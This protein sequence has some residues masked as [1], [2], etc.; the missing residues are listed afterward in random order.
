MFNKKLAITV[1]VVLCSLLSGARAQSS[2]AN[3]GR[4]QDRAEIRAHI[5]SIF[6]AFIDWD[7]DKIYATHSEDWH[8]L[9]EGSPVPIK[10]IDEYMI[11]NGIEWPKRDPNSK[12]RPN[13]S[14][15]YR[16]KDFDVAFHGPTLAVVSFIG[17]FENKSVDP[18]ATFRRLRIMDVYEKRDGH[19]IQVASHTVVDPAWRDE[20][21]SLPANLSPEDRE[22]I[23]KV[24]E[25]VWRAFFSNDR[26]SLEKLIPEDVIAIDEGSQNWSNRESILAAAKSFADGGGKLIKLEFPKTE[27]QVYGNTIVLYTTFSYELEANGKHLTRSGRGTE[28]FVRRNGSLVNTGWHLDSS[29]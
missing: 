21:N 25:S 16:V 6:Q 23:L 8:G 10:G 28:I 12:P 1:L 7:V 19:W 14:V 20:R 29:E 13:P 27:M 18:P 2:S 15:G 4:D 5:E 24:R 22:K 9:L 17:E 11:A 26:P 3:D